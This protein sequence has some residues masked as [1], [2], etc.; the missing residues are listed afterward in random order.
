MQEPVCVGQEDGVRSLFLQEVEEHSCV[1]QGR[2]YLLVVLSCWCTCLSTLACVPRE[3][4]SH[5]ARIHL[6]GG[7]GAVGVMFK[8]A[9]ATDAS[10]V[11][12]GFDREYALT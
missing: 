10:F 2:E 8:V 1:V 5:D 6:I 3:Q 11:L 4:V 9:T 7:C 12:V